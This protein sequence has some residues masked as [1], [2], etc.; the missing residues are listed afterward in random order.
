MN[1]YVLYVSI[2]LNGILLMILAG[3]VP[4]LLY[5]SI[6]V[7]LVLAWFSIGCVKNISDIEEDMDA[8][9]SKTDN[10]TEHLESVHE[11]E[12]FYGDETLQGMIDHSKQL[13]NDYIDLQAK[14]FDVEV[15][16]EEDEDDTSETE[17]EAPPAA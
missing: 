15:T 9:M 12:I 5:L 6:I 4:F 17:E 8:I 7:N 16:I 1:K 10:F 2:V 14:Y 13:V 3:V 11:M